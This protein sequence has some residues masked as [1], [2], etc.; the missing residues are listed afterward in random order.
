M[1][2][3]R[4]RRWY[5]SDHTDIQWFRRGRECLTCRH[6]F[7][8]AEVTE[9][10]I[11]ELVEL[12]EK[13]AKKN[14]ESITRIRK[15]APWIVREEMI[16]KEIAQQFIRRSAWWLTH[17]SGMPVRARGHARRIYKSQH[18]WTVVFG[19][20]SFLVGK[21][22]ERCRNEIN[23]FFEEASSG[24]LPRLSDLKKLLC[25]QISGAVANNDGYEYDGYYPITDGQLIFGAQ[26]IDVNDGADYLIEEAE[27]GTLFL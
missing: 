13:L 20:N 3:P 15:K 21:A 26:A 4:E 18:G 5:R 16:P 23:N 11:E 17:S 19:G 7:L 14:Q 2:K 27:L 9:D 22:V 6:A 8:T 1:K 24:K 12:R 10:F 25:R